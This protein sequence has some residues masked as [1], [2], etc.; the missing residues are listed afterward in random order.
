MLDEKILNILKDRIGSYVSGEEMCES[1]GVSR[2]AI[3][4]W[5]EKL[6]LEGYDIEASPHLGYRLKSIP[7]SLIPI[8]IKW[9]LRTKILGKEIISYKKVSSTNDV[10]Y[11]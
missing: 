6:R 5:I 4:K 11:E 9:K 10:A 2:T 7:D 3:W 8:E 1:I